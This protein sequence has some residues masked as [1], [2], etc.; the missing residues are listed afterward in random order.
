M[1]TPNIDRIKKERGYVSHQ[2]PGE[3][4][5]LSQDPAE[6]KNLYGER[7]EIVKELK[8]LLEKYKQ[9]SRSVPCRPDAKAT[10]K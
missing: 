10:G 2:F 3:L 5:D 8:A 7:P 4:Y 9:E 1:R 6:H